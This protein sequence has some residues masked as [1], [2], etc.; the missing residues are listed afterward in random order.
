MHGGTARSPGRT[1]LPLS[2]HRDD[3]ASVG[4]DHVDDVAA[5][6]HDRDRSWGDCGILLPLA[7]PQRGVRFDT[8]HGRVSRPRDVIARLDDSSSLHLSLMRRMGGPEM[9]T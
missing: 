5:D 1:R 3:F 4:L 2:L 6:S 9:D 8:A 7:P